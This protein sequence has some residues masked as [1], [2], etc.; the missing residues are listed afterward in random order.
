MGNV[1]KL[2]KRIIDLEKRVAKL[3]NPSISNLN[4]T[5]SF[6]SKIVERIDDIGIQHLVLLALK[7]KQKQSRLELKQKV[8]SWQK[9]IGTWFDGSSIKIRLLDTH[10]II[11][12]GKDEKN[13]E[14]YSLGS[15][16]VR[17]VKDLIK[18]Y[19]LE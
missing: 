6:E 9:P 10:Q 13:K 4:S 7:I 3:E 2:E 14:L 11:R 8:A 18:K 1:E 19:E 15:K 17:T 12:D 5:T 16:G